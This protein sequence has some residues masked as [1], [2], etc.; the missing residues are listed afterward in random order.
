MGRCPLPKFSIPAI[1]SQ[2]FGLGRFLASDY[3]TPPENLARTMR[4]EEGTSF[5]EPDMLRSSCLLLLVAVCGCHAPMPSFKPFAPYGSTRIPAPG[6]GSFGTPDPYYRPPAQPSTVPNSQGQVLSNGT[7]Y[8]ARTEG[9]NRESDE[10]AG[11]IW[12]NPSAAGGRRNTSII[13]PTP[14][15]RDTD[16]PR[17]SRPVIRA[18]YDEPEYEARGNDP[19]P[20]ISIIPPT[21]PRAFT[22]GRNSSPLR[23][24]GM[25]FTDA[26]GYAESA[27]AAGSRSAP[28]DIG[29][30]PEPPSRLR[31][32]LRGLSNSLDE[33]ASA[34]GTTSS[35]AS[36]TTTSDG[37]KTR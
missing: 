11:V 24:D 17:N 32:R 25:P 8:W 3:S 30:L 19:A 12:S 36:R 13:A 22:P 31:A 29:H 9:S 33:P 23:M 37:W 20:G 27:G 1:F 16:S 7:E 4:R 2:D 35:T 6:T 34:S 5:L 28:V 18:S 21:A 26:T 15:I 14:S 10:S